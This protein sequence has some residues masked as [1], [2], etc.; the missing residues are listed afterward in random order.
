MILYIIH[1]FKKKLENIEVVKLFVIIINF[2]W[3]SSFGVNIFSI[4]KLNYLNL[5]DVV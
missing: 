2:I 5:I 3:L 1:D 4:I